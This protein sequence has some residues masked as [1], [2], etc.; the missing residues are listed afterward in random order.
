ML[1]SIAKIVIVQNI[2]FFVTSERF[3]QGLMLSL[4]NKLKYKGSPKLMSDECVL[5]V[6]QNWSILL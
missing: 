5:K 2:L 6:G 3:S 1:Y 4:N